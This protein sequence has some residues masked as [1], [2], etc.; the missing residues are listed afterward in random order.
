LNFEHKIFAYLR[1][2]RLGYGVKFLCKKTPNG[3]FFRHRIRRRL[4]LEN[5]CTSPFFWLSKIGKTVANQ[6][7]L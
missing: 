7:E 3:E 2:Q 5:I 6:V 4:A 1:G